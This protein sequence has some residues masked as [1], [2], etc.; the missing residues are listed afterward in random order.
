MTTLPYPRPGKLLAPLYAYKPIGIVAICASLF[1]VSFFAHDAA[2][3]ARS[4]AA[5]SNSEATVNIAKLGFSS[6]KAVAMIDHS[7]IAQSALLP[8]PD[9][10]LLHSNPTAYQSDNSPTKA[11][12][13]AAARSV[14]HPS[15]RYR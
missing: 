12:Q 3:A 6:S 2:Q 8:D 15:Y 5:K 11:E 7:H 4:D 13:E 9:P 10:S 14:G 1:L